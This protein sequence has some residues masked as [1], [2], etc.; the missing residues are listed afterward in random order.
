MYND[1]TVKTQIRSN[2]MKAIKRIIAAMLAVVMLLGFAA[3]GEKTD[4][5]TTE[6]V[7][8]EQATSYIRETKTKIAVLDGITRI[9]ISK[10]AKDR[11][12]NYETTCYATE[13]E[14]AELIK[15]GSADMA[16]LPVDSAAKLYTET[17]GAIQLVAVNTLGFYHILEKGEKI[18]SV[19]DLKGKTVYAAYKGTGY[20]A[21]INHI[22]AENG[23]DPEKDIDLQFKETDKEVATLTGDGTAEIL[24]L[25]EPY[26]SKVVSNEASYRKALDLNAEW[27]KISET[28]LAQTAIVARKEYIDANS[29]I[30]SEFDSFCKISV[31]YLRTN[32]Y[33]APVFLAENGICE[34]VD[35]ATEVILGSNLYYLSGEEMKAA[36]AAVL[37]VCGITVDDA[38]YY[39]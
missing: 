26:A 18:K 4:V 8:T 38:F 11:E 17:N 37:A 33:G 28:P 7:L 10:F 34:T 24:I 30:I 22:L 16:V 32:T 12:Y 25:P 15:N 29:D 20:E 5:E 2:F 31:N 21:V 1:V 36:V 9:G 6:D 13:A 3:C 23:I 19:A 39:V 35:L 27:N 14:V